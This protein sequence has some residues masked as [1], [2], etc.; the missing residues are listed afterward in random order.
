MG[1]CSVSEWG[2]W[3]SCSVTCGV[4]QRFRKRMF[5]NPIVDED[6][7]GL[8]LM[9][10]ENCI[11]KLVTNSMEFEFHIQITVPGLHDAKSLFSSWE[12]FYMMQYKIYDFGSF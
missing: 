2:D 4:G 12:K 6:M 1:K 3:S 9:E 7:C 10:S 8:P 5:H 11:G